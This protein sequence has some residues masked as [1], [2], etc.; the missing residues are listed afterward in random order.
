M[1]FVFQLACWH[2][3]A[4]AWHGLGSRVPSMP[5]GPFRNSAAD[6]PSS[7]S[8]CRVRWIRGGLAGNQAGAA[9]KREVFESPLNEN[10]HAALKFYNVDQVDKEPDQPCGQPRNVKAKNVSDGR[11]AAD[12]GHI[13]L[14]EVVKRRQFRLAL[15][16]RPDSLCR[17]GASL[18]RYLRNA[19]QLL[20][21]LVHGEGE[22]AD[23]E[24]VRIGR[25]REVAVDLDS[26]A[27]IRFRLGA[28]REFAPKWC[29][30]NTAGPKHGPRCQSLH[31]I[32]ALKFDT[33]FINLRHHNALDDFHAESR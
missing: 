20:P 12:D 2:A 25:D 4:R 14:I 32:S 5:G 21:F 27:A 33:F 13:P 22:I 29:R 3:V 15:Q 19:G 30:H 16:A 17:V 6:A 28:L 10:D 9:A 24:N 8:G 7:C 1:K 31:G 11:G 26:A 23:D 18:N